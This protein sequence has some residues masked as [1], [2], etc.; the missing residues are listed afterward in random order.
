V[1]NK[2]LKSSREHLL[3]GHRS[4]LAIFGGL[5]Q[6]DAP[7]DE[8]ISEKV[9][10]LFINLG[11]DLI[12]IPLCMSSVN[13]SIEKIEQKVPPSSDNNEQF[14][15]GVIWADCLSLLSE[16][17]V[18]LITTDKAFY[19]GKAY[20][21]G[22]A[23][24]LAL[25]AKAFKEHTLTLRSS[26]LDFILEFRQDVQVPE[27]SIVKAYM[28]EGFNPENLL[29]DTDY[30]V[31]E[32]L[33]VTQ[34]TFI[35]EDPARLFVEFSITFVAR[36]KSGLRDGRIILSGNGTFD[37]SGKWLERLQKSEEAIEYFDEEG[38][39]KRRSALFAYAN[40]VVGTKSVTH[41]I[42]SKLSNS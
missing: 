40:I 7:T 36:S 31:E 28:H 42:K 10:Q 15:D 9:D 12:E 38:Q 22:L 5:P 3:K 2:H 41:T 26:L 34:S 32:L 16:S 29:K 39:S 25:E 19:E 20:S 17:D 30:S 27:E 21:G 11:V 6:F 24:N 1:L 33:E 13:S 35:T 4:L 14:R 23:S 18:T 37:T 8:A